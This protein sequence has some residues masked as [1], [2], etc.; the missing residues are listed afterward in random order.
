MSDF[1]GKKI[2]LG[3][4]GGISAYKII[5][6]ARQL[7][8]LGA[9]VRVVMTDSAQKFVT[10]LT[11]QAITGHAVSTSLWDEERERSMGHIELGKWAD[12]LVIAPASANFIAKMAHGIADDL[13]STLYLVTR[14]PV[15]ICPAMN[16]AMY[17]H[18]AT[19]EN[20]NTLTLRGN[21]ILGPDSGEQA[22]G[23][24]GLGRL[25]EPDL[26]I[27]AL[28]LAPFESMFL[29]QKIIITAGATKEPI[30]PVR[31]ISNES[32]GKMGIALANAC[33]LLG[34]NVTVITHQAAP[35]T[36]P[37]I[38]RIEVDNATS[39]HK[40]VMKE[41]T[42]NSWFIGAAA[43]ADFR[44]QD[45]LS[46]KK[47]KTSDEW[48]LNLVK[49][50]DIISDV[51][52]K[53]ICSRVIGFAAETENVLD[54]AREKMNKKGLDAI[55]A[56]QVGFQKGFGEDNHEVTIL[57]SDSLTTFPLKKQHKTR[58]AREIVAILASTFQNT[59][60]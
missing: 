12:Y 38:K 37:S 60:I 56:N 32:S 43:V 45:I 34:A 59:P 24:E 40:E 54:Y 58:L 20:L 28:R 10:P 11:F 33:A 53:R 50:P 55:I 41:I 52:Q 25:I 14:A 7:I 9:D 15:L 36:F 16:Q 18:P 2:L 8:T 1:N 3:I 42:K 17:H 27:E 30:D 26:I 13:L 57:F 31:Y 44:V 47:K 49:N 21:T 39:M 22:C 5:Y 29:N 48:N 19:Q 4:C 6:L 23:D 46:S 35:K 51:V